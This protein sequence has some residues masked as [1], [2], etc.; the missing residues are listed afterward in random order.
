[1][2]FLTVAILAICAFGPAFA[3]DDGVPPIPIIVGLGPSASGGGGGGNASTLEGKTWEA[4]G[5]IGSTTP[6]TGA[7]TT[8]TVGSAK[9]SVDVNGNI[10]T[11]NN[12]A[13]SFPSVQGAAGTF[14]SNDGAGNLT[15]M[16]GAAPTNNFNALTSGTNTAA[17]MVVGTG[18]SL[19]TSG[20]GT[21]AATSAATA[22]AVP[23]SGVSSA[24]N[25]TGALVV[26]TGGSLA[27]SG[28]GTIAATS[29]PFSG[30]S[31][32]TNATAAMHVGTGASLDATG[33]GT[34]A[35]TT[36][37]TATTAGAVPFSGVTSSTNTT[38][39]LV[40]G[41]G[42]SLATSGSGTINATALNGATFAAPGTIGGGTPGPATFTAVTDT[43]LTPDA[44]LYSGTGGLLTTAGAPTD[45][46]VLIGSTGAAPVRA[47]LTAG[48][49]VTITPGAGSITIAAAGS[50]TPSFATITSGT[51][52][53]AA[54]V[55]GTGSSL[56]VSGSG[57]NNATTL[58][59]ATFAAPG[60]IG[61]TTP[62]SVAATTI[63]ATGQITS[64]LATG[65][66]PLVVAST[67]NVANL[68]ASSLSGATFA[69]P[70]PIGSGTPGT[71]AFTTLSAGS[72]KF[73]VDANG[74]VTK[75]NNV[76]QSWP[77]ANAAGGLQ[78][79]GSG[80][81]SWTSTPAITLPWSSLTAPTGNL[82]L[83]M[84]ANTTAFT[85]NTA[86]T[87]NQWAMSTSSL[88][89]GELVNLS[90]T[91]A[92]AASNTQTVLGVAT[93]G[94][95]SNSAQTTYATDVANTHT[96]TSSTNVAL[97]ATASG[98]TSANYA[99]LTSGDV[100]F[101]TATPA[102]SFENANA[103]ASSKPGHLTS[104]AWFT[105]GSSTGTK[106]QLLVE[107]TGTTSNGW[108]VTGTGLGINAA[109]GFTGN[110]FDAQ[111]NAVSKFKM[112]TTTLTASPN[113]AVS[114]PVITGTGTWFTGGS[115]TT[116]KPYV[117]I[118][119]TGTTS[120]GWATTGTGMGVNAASGFTGKL[121]D[122]QLTGSSRF[123]VGANGGVA[124]GIS[125]SI[126]S[127]TSA[128]AFGN[129]AV[130]S[131]NSSVA[132]GDNVSANNGTLSF[133]VAIGNRSTASGSRSYAIGTNLVSSGAGSYTIGSGIV[134][135][136]NLANPINGGLMY[137]YNIGTPTLQ[138]RGGGSYTGTGTV[139]T[140]ST[141]ATVTGSGSTF[142]NDYAIGDKITI[143]ANT[144]TVT[145]TAS[146]T[147]MT[148]SPAAVATVSGQAHTVLA[149]L[150]SIHDSSN[151]IQSITDSSGNTA[152]GANIAHGKLD[153]DAPNVATAQYGQLNIGAASTSFDGTTSGFFAGSASG[154]QLAVNAASGFVGSLADLQTAGSSKF[155][156]DYTGAST[157]TNT[158][159]I[160]GA[161]ATQRALLYQTAGSARWN[162]RAGNG[163][164]SGANAGSSYI[165]NAFDDSGVTIDNPLVITRAAGGAF[166]VAR[167]LALSASTS[168][169]FLNMTDGSADAVSASNEGR[170]RYNSST[171]TFQISSNG[172]AFASIGSGAAFSAITSGTNTT[173]AMIIDTGASLTINS[174]SAFTSSTNIFGVAAAH[175]G[176]INWHAADETTNH[177]WQMGPGVSG[178]GFDLYDA[179]SGQPRI[180]V[181]AVDGA[182]V[183]NSTTAS[184]SSASGSLI[185]SGGLGVAKAA[186]IGGQLVTT[187]NGAT[188]AAPLYANGTW[189]TGGGTTNTKPQLLIEPAGTTTTA[190]SNA[191]TGIGANAPAAFAGNLMDLQ[192]NGVSQFSV[193]A[194]GAIIGTL[195]WNSLSAPTGNAAIAMAARTTNF[196]WDT[197]TTGNQW[198]L[199]SNSLSSGVLSTVNCTS[200][201]AN[202]NTQQSFRV[203]NS[204]ANANTTQTT[205]AA[206]FHNTKTGTA[207]V[208]VAALFNA[209]NGDT[210]YGIIVQAGD[211][212]FQTN[213]P[214]ATFEN[215]AIGQL[216]KPGQLNSGT[217][218]TGG[219]ATTCKPYTLI[220]V[221]G[222]TSNN[223]STAGT[224]FGINGPTSFAGNL[225]DAQVDGS[226]KFK[227]TAA[228]NVTSAGTHAFSTVGTGNVYKSGTGAYAGNATLVGGT[229][230]VTCATIGTNS[231]VSLTRKTSG[232]TIGTAIT[233]TISNGASFTITSD[234]I[235]DTST[236][237]YV[238]SDT[239]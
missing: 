36:A 19:A 172:G 52:T 55:L 227:V 10:I 214:V 235:L 198:V 111:L 70:G 9:F 179:T 156:V 14:L 90:S 182:L 220:Q 49:N 162:V 105:G 236:F 41:T 77:A 151:V 102:A 27:T 6:N 209:V 107:P 48:S 64:T 65:T 20:S 160:T 196:T 208:D 60:A 121:I 205:Y 117:L 106:P 63:S 15:W 213:T 167:P 92:D 145:A 94:A 181:A 57:T 190:W 171:Q 169:T 86:T 231:V 207:S 183:L 114:T 164:E 45:G 21:I 51:N 26:G 222:A 99:L 234:N 219:T 157:T 136:T 211:V 173:A 12:V 22:A 79:D 127:G 74:N 229:V 166:T 69:A 108:P 155:K 215:A 128:V 146:N 56:T 139:S 158:A 101:G 202:G 204:G 118:E 130:A 91:S 161:A 233:Y 218:I 197:A 93:S 88:T 34:I 126:A 221:T 193:S 116:T 42:G 80:N 5:T 32:G 30:V 150:F 120:T 89:S 152:L 16:A 224:G 83:A 23:F 134:L 85:Y 84:G 192:V 201:A 178:D 175:N 168:T 24:T 71:G 68:N 138:A 239:N 104:G 135:S 187:A 67:T 140:T 165:I 144:Y 189:F 200:T 149:H 4:P 75:L 177:A 142:L 232:G 180:I 109:S 137:G 1:M 35:A 153:V 228:G 98:G 131:G 174:G 237:S 143:G 129:V 18:A 113:G 38:G 230:T 226:A 216:S 188:N 141:N 124:G 8:L 47:S 206:T 203:T 176:L 147:S 199:S 25:T 37:T 194:A 159:N 62:G 73:T 61:G 95:N 103:G 7:F 125:T 154:T 110:L 97:R 217:W 223:W 81:L 59:G 148:I 29:A 31:S 225:I 33:S 119:P 186:F 96:G 11:L 58:N 17:A 72:G 185:T 66:A 53:G 28:S 170:L 54:M 122:A 184:T 3:V 82:A 132:L 238:V 212:G 195:P 115:A 210:N 13:T 100:G 76:T 123:S 44:F 46:Q 40:V 50:A 2:R 39:A 87:G 133:S 112:S 163:A 191:G 78:N 43:S